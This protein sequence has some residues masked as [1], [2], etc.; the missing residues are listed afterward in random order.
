MGPEHI[1]SFRA[2]DVLLSFLVS[3]SPVGFMS[4]LSSALYNLCP[5][6]NI[7]LPEVEDRPS[8]GQGLVY[9][10]CHPSSL[11]SNPRSRYYE[12]NCFSP[13]HIC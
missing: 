11:T 6:L 8:R 2:I 4:S 5:S 12:L 9:P 1:N 13:K 3:L 10:L 7:I